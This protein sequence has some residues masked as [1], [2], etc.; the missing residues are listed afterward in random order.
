MTD[1]DMTNEQKYQTILG[2]R[3]D[4]VPL[5]EDFDLV[6]PETGRRAGVSEQEERTRM[7][8]ISV[9]QRVLNRGRIYTSEQVV[10]LLGAKLNIPRERAVNGFEMMRSSGVLTASSGSGFRLT[11]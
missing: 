11:I 4:L 5:V 9:A 2:T 3:P 10:S 7:K 8:L 1:D 6:D